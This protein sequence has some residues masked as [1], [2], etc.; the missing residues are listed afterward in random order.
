[1]RQL[2]RHLHDIA[3]HAER[4]AQLERQAEAVILAGRITAL[5]RK[6]ARILV[7]VEVYTWSELADAPAAPEQPTMRNLDGL[8][9]RSQP[10]DGRGRLLG[11]AWLRRA[12]ALNAADLAWFR[13]PVSTGV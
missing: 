1:M 11:K 5:C 12:E 2:P 4:R 9:Y 10:R 8:G 7:D 13:H 6:A 3:L